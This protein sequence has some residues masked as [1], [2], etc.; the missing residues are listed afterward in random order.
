MKR[1]LSLLFAVSLLLVAACDKDNGAFQDPATRKDAVSIKFD[2]GEMPEMT[3]SGSEVTVTGIDITEASRYV[4]YLKQADATFVRTGRFTV[5]NGVYNLNDFGSVELLEGKVAI[6]PATGVSVRAGSGAHIY[7]A[8]I[9]PFSIVGAIAL[10]LARNWKV[11]STYVKVT[12]VKNNYSVAPSIFNGCDFHEIA[13]TLKEMKIKLSD[14]D[15]AS[16]DGYKLTEISFIGNNWMVMGFSGREPY[17]GIWN[18]NGSNIA[19]EL[20]DGNKL[21]SAKC[22]G[23][24][25]FPGNGKARLL[26][27][28]TV[29]GGDEQYSGTIELTL[30]QVN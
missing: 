11:E 26:I 8:T 17:F 27:N 22:T 28:T 18:L 13:S 15:V 30:V 25:S 23:T 1:F 3:I 24:V 20:N 4:L 29:T 10:N 5:A 12:G 7:S 21:L 14:S 2:K 19:W 6:S 9:N 16:L